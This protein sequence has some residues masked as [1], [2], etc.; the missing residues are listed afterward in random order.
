MDWLLLRSI[1]KALVLPPAGPLIVAIAG[2]AIASRAPRTGRA[3]AWLGVV[4]LLLLCMPIVASALTGLFDQPAFDAAR[5]RQAGAIVILG[6]GTRRAAPEYGGDTLGRLTAERVRYGARVARETRLPVLVSGGTPPQGS[7]SEAEVMRQAL[8]QEYAV[9]VRWVEDRSRNTRE[10]AQHASRLLRSE[11][12]DRIVLVAHAYDLPRATREFNAAG[13][14][15][16]PAA[17]GLPSHG[18]IAPMD[19]LPSVAALQ[20]SWHALYELLANAVWTPPP[21]AKATGAR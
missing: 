19:F 11:R 7:R 9:G 3:I 20:S 15:V 13:I 1:A 8:E 4:S 12:I 14:E 17:T 18:P 16:V 21:A 5:A 2:L 6:G 10:N